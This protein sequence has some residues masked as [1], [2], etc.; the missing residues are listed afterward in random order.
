ALAEYAFHVNQTAQ[1]IGARRLYTIMERLL[2][3]LS[4]EAPE[5]KMGQVTIN[6]AYVKQRLESVSQ[7][8]DLSKFIL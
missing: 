2:E 1:N 8:E 4:F 5:M 3:E 6:A 7:D